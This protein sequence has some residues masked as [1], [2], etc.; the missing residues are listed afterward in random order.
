[1]T[2]V[3]PRIGTI[4]AGIAAVLILSLVLNSWIGIFP[5]ALSGVSPMKFHLHYY[6]GNVIG[7][8]SSAAAYSESG[9]M[10]MQEHLQL[11]LLPIALMTARMGLRQRPSFQIPKTP[12]LS[13]QAEAMEAGTV[14]TVD[15]EDNSDGFKILVSRL[16]LLGTFILFLLNSMLGLLPGILFNQQGMKIHP[17][18]ALARL[19]GMDPNGPTWSQSAM[20]SVQE[21]MMI[22]LMVILVPTALAIRPKPSENETPPSD[23]PPVGRSS[24]RVI[25]PLAAEVIASVLGEAHKVDSVTVESALGEM[26]RIVESEFNPT[27][28]GVV[29]DLADETE[30]D[31]AEDETEEDVSEEETEEDV[32][33]EETEEDD[34]WNIE[35][36]E[37]EFIL[38]SPKEE[39][40]LHL[41]Q[42]DVEA[43]EHE[44]EQDFI[45]DAA[46]LL[47]IESESKMESEPLDVPVEI[48]SEESK[49]EGE[50]EAEEAVDESIDEN[51]M[52]SAEVEED[53][54][55]I[56]ESVQSVSS[57]RS[58]TATISG[59]MF[60][61]PTSL[62]ATAE[63]DPKTGRWM[64]N[65][66]PVGPK[67]T[68]TG[69]D[70]ESSSGRRIGGD[71]PL[72]E[73]KKK[74][75]EKS[76]PAERRGEKRGA[77][78]EPEEEA[79]L[80][81]KTKDGQ[82]EHE[83]LPDMPQM[84]GRPNAERPK[85]RKDDVELPDMPKF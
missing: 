80:I 73:S 42:D 56:P 27:P 30:D 76:Q 82:K 37:P 61:R 57:P 19:I 21:I 58:S 55:L 59:E 50:S 41:D 46:T 77:K 25:N 51:D 74:A 28:L 44:V 31:V 3:A 2:R 5:A 1:M 75:E 69:I 39:A 16:L 53:S 64:I 8:E 12:S 83:A 4:A 13:E 17:I 84:T 38:E 24:E 81:K 22:W 36:S 49:L 7:L 62:P 66:V 26:D 60:I 65:G 14:A 32:S 68:A 20:L 15:A 34:V 40:K 18:Y 67:V 35:S 6:L 71:D 85:E 52:D 43:I 11:I 10:S 45:P 48:D 23:L 9:V 54:E 70:S 79:P 33:E 72:K 63:L 47:G 78:I 29:A